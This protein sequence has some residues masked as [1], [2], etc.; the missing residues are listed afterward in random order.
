M[1]GSH[2]LNQEGAIKDHPPHRLLGQKKG[3]QAAGFSGY[4]HVVNRCPFALSVSCLYVCQVAVIAPG[5]LFC[6][7]AG[8]GINRH[9][10][11]GSGLNN[12]IGDTAEHNLFQALVAMGP[13]DD[14][15]ALPVYG[16]VN[17][18]LRHITH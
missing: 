16:I 8:V 3:E 18:L 11:T 7:T 13:H 2:L 12:L 1:K 17:D 15:I 6:K 9:D 4:C 10:R 14:Q 5:V